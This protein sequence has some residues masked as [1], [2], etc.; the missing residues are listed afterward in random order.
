MKSYDVLDEAL[1]SISSAAPDLRNGLTNHAPMA[2]EAMCAMGRGD[3]VL[4][5]LDA[6]RKSMD[7]W[8]SAGRRV[9]PE[10]W[11][12]ALGQ[13]GRVADWRE[14][15]Q[16]EL[17]EAPWRDVLDR[18]T[19]RLCPGISAS[20]T[21]G[22]IR[23]G[24]AVRSLE[25]AETA[26]R[27]SELASSLAY[28]ASTYQSL[29]S[30]LS[31]NPSAA[32]VSE[33]IK[34]VEVVPLQDRVYAGSI[35]S[36]LLALDN[37][38]PFAP[39]IG[40]AD[41]RGSVMSVVSDLA[42]VFARVYLA[43]AHDPLTAIVFIHSVTSVAALRKMAPHITEET[44]RKA[45]RF[46]W[47]AGCGLYAT[48]GSFPSPVGQIAESA[49]SSET[50][51]DMAIAGGDEHGIKFTEACL[52]EAALRPSVVYTAAVRHALATLTG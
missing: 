9:S 44:A 5:W 27:Y 12:D 21:H 45:M 28:W 41:L 15:F 8:P 19:A 2:V 35:T 30:D 1:A 48:F 18:W 34:R 33:A 22:V 23:V 43:N 51:I 29:P 17:Q 36:S 50:L 10:K 6:Y 24:H 14:F 52:S 37:F 32:P 46:A 47:Q 39:V 20:A 7:A 25:V 49:E 38:P 40:L 26:A 42:E 13:P 31:A 11:R 3:A 16:N 4:S